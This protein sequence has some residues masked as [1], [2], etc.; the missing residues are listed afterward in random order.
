MNVLTISQD[1]VDNVHADL[2]NIISL[3]YM[4]FVALS[5]VSKELQNGIFHSDHL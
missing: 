2:I 3:V 5:K 4:G 1:P